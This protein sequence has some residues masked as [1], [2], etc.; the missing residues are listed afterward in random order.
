MYNSAEGL[1]DQQV[2][3]PQ[4]ANPKLVIELVPVIPRR[5][6]QENCHKFKVSLKYMISSRPACAKE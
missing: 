5:L 3:L 6:E 4:K 1:K 2:T